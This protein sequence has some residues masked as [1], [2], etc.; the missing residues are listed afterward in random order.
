MKPMKKSLLA[1]LFLATTW[2]QAE[3]VYATFTVEA[4]QHANLAFNAGGVVDRVTVTVGSIVH[5][6]D[7][8]ASLQS[9]DIRAALEIRRT[10]LK[11]A[12]KAYDRLFSIKQII[13]EA[14]LDSVRFNYENAQA[15]L[16][17]QQAILDK[18]MLHTPF[19]GMITFKHVE[20]GDTVSGVSL[21][22]LLQIESLHRRKL[23]LSFDQKYW[24]AVKPGQTFSYK[25]D[26]DQSLYRGKITKLYP[27]SSPKNRKMTAEVEAMDIPVGLFGT[28]TIQT[29]TKDSE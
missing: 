23:I 10:A 29:D 20:K 18:T 4:K 12:K 6:G 15:Q 11:Y 1:V 2:L 17:Y 9:T 26:G 7:L 14:K 16:N 28:G 21:R 5:E 22:T 24:K 8:L 13:D 19:D 3:G 27:T 25:I